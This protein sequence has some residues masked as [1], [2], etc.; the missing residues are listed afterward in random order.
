M[1]DTEELDASKKVD[2]KVLKNRSAMVIK[3]EKQES[4]L[5]KESY[6]GKTKEER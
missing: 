4:E 1:E 3:I 5:E 2:F 6:Y